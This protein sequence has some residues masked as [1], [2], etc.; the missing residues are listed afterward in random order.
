MSEPILYELDDKSCPSCDYSSDSK[1][2]IRQHHKMAHDESIPNLICVNCDEPFFSKGRDNLYCNECKH[3]RYEGSNNP[4]YVD[5]EEK[6]TCEN[7]KA[8]FK[9]YPS[10]KKGRFCQQ[11]QKERPW[12]KERKGKS[13]EV[14]CSYCEDFKT[15]SPS[16]YD[17][18]NEFFCNTECLSDWRSENWTGED[19]PLWKGG[20]ISD[21]GGKWSSVRENARKRDNYGCVMCGKTREDMGYGPEVHHIIPVREHENPQNAH[22]I[23]NV[24]SLC[25]TCHA[26]AEHG[27]ITK[28]TLRD[29]I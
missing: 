5:A 27:N 13:V 29:K 14:R 21:Y 9:Y 1:R 19:H 4:N 7:C 6:T 15:V 22:R 17:K 28:E 18:N 12:L 20:E 24:V 25:S 3:I 8:K 16:V 2:G 10:S 11:C 23:E 26:N